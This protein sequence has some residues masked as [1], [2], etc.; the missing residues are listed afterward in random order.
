MN[1][2]SSFLTLGGRKA[3]CYKS[4]PMTPDYCAVSSA[5]SSASAS[6]DFISLTSNSV[7]TYISTICSIVTSAQ[8]SEGNFAVTT[9]EILKHN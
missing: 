1:C 7:S 9:A 5:A 6:D 4:E 2:V 3:P 8:I